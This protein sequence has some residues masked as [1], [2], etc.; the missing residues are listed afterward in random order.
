MYG[1]AQI[2]SLRWRFSVRGRHGLA[3]GSGKRGDGIR[4][5]DRSAECTFLVF[6]F[7]A[8][9]HGV[10][11]ND[12]TWLQ[13]ETFVEQQKF[14]VT[15]VWDDS[16]TNLETYVMECEKEI[17]IRTRRVAVELCWQ[18]IVQFNDSLSPTDETISHLYTTVTSSITCTESSS[19]MMWPSVTSLSF[20]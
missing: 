6:Y 18:R 17:L 11:N 20:V 13:G 10:I 14:D 2:A 7:C 3:T 1:N 9:C 16:K 12:L 4:F 5:V 19:D 8:A 15:S